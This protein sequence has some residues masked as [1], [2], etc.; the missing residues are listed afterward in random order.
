MMTIK[1]VYSSRLS[2]L[3][4]GI[5]LQQLHLHSLNLLKNYLSISLEN[6]KKFLFCYLDFLRCLIENNERKVKKEKLRK[7]FDVSL[8]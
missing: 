6:S 8:E 5:N 7:V 4:L 2:G 1:N 3:I